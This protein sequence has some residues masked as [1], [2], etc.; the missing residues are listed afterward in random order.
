MSEVN[1]HESIVLTDMHCVILYCKN[2]LNTGTDALVRSINVD[3]RLKDNSTGN[4]RFER[5]H[6]C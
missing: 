6:A 3:S 1:A 4:S 2:A 5:L